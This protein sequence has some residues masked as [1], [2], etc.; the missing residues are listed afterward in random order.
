MKEILKS[1]KSL[2][3][4][5]VS[6]LIK[7]LQSLLE[8]RK[9][10]AAKE[11]EEKAAKEKLTQEVRAKIEAL[12]AE[13]GMTLEM[14]G[15]IPSSLPA[16]PQ[17]KRSKY[18]YNVNNQ[19]FAVNDQ[20]KVSLLFTRSLKQHKAEG[21]ALRYADLTTEQQS[22]AMALIEKRNG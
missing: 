18:E 12:I 20:G 13:K 6:Q 8:K 15:L 1:A 14:L 21:K 16:Q 10:K 11:A 2:S 7:S 17:A 3:D 5:E 4:S 19:Y 22:Q 9:L